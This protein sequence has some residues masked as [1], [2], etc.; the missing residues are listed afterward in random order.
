M[1]ILLI[2]LEPC[3][4]RLEQQ[5]QQFQNIG[6]T[7][8]RLP[9]VSV[10]DFSIDS[11]EQ[12]AFQGQRPMKQSELACFLSH[13]K[14]WQHVVD[15]NEPCLILE[16]D[17]VLVS[18]LKQILQ[19]VEGLTA[20]DVLSLEV[21]GR[22]KIIAKEKSFTV[23]QDYALFR[24][25]QDRSGAAAYVLFPSGAKKLLTCLENS[26]P[27]LA[28]EF[29]SSCYALNSYQI[30]PAA[31]I[32]SDKAAMY[33]VGVSI[34]HESVIAMI[35]NHHVNPNSQRWTAKVKHKKNRIVQQALLGVRH[36]SVLLKSVRRDI[37]VEPSKFQK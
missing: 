28:D 24:M 27:R 9:A 20:V 19:D 30:E 32:Q 22:K 23:A 11:Y 21:H 37:K 31:A 10:N 34:T 4:E 12:L 29:I 18:E 33:D 3:T 16:D 1:H 35:K 7:F 25:Y 36:V 15:L 17:V 26:H 8:S 13:K 2:N 6:L 14:A 5:Q